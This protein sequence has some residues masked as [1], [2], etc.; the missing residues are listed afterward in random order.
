MKKELTKKGKIIRTV[1]IILLILILI[2]VLVVGGYLL[3][4]IFSYHRIGNIDLEIR[5]GASKNVIDTERELTMTSYN[6]GFG[7]YSDDYTF[8]MDTGTD[9]NGNKTQGE[10]GKAVSLEAV[11]KNMEGSLKAIESLSSDFIALQEVDMDADRSYHF[12]Q[13]EYFEK[14]LTGYDSTFAVDFDSAYLFYPFHDPHGKSKAGLS[15]FSRYAMKESKRREYTIATDFSKYMDLDRCFSVHRM[16][17][18]D[19]KEFVLIN[20]HMSAYDEGGLIRDKQIEELHSFM[21]AEYE[22][23]NYVIT[24]GDFNHD[25]LTNNPLY[26]MY[27]RENYPYQDEIDQG[28]PS[29][30]NYIYDENKKSSFDDGFKVYA[31]DNE[32]SCRDADVVYEKGSTFVSTLD[33][34]IVSD[35]IEVKS[36]RTARTGE[37]GF[38]YSD[39]QPTTLTFLLKE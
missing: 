5:E 27:T 3:Y 34:F 37:N 13:Q 22:K 17:T 4:V 38:A 12:N 25:L 24:T 35:N 26:P 19:R 7:A 28:Y 30:V 36:V 15:T 1:I 29:W 32:P 20:S 31:A 6:V 2:P 10:H 9:K 23:G 33:G 18:A 39:H 21:K 8:F 16:D 11:K 14:N